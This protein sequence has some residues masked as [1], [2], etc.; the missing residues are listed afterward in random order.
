MTDKNRVNSSNLD[1]VTA[2]T[3][4]PV[5]ANILGAP[6]TFGVTLAANTT[7]YFPVGAPKAPVQ[8]EVSL[9]A[10]H[11]RGITAAMVITAIG[12]EDSC[13]P[14]ATSPGDGR[15]VVDVTDFDTS[16]GAWVPENPSTATVA[17]TGTGWTSTAGVAAAAGTGAGAAMFNIGNLGSRRGRLRVQ[18]GATGG[19]ARVAVH[20]KSAA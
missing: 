14:A 18:V 6:A 9:I 17:T 7:Y 11:I 13:M 12:F 10:I 19:L 16:A 4:V 2:T 8:A 5:V 20:G 1:A 15:G 3:G